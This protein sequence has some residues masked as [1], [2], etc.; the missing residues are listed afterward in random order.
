MNATL[1]GDTITRHAEVHMGVAVALP[2]GLVVPVL[3]NAD[4]M[5]LLR[6]PARP[7]CWPDAHTRA[8]SR[9]TT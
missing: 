5:G 8:A 4:D 6:S 7:A 3:H 9:L 2:E 1:D